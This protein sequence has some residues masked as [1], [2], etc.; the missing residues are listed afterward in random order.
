MVDR[1]FSDAAL[2]D[3]YDAFC[4]WEERGD[5]DY[6]LP[7]IMAADAVLD[8]GCG[9]GM[10][11][12]RAREIGHT[13]RLTGL[14]PAAAMLDVARRRDDIEWVRGTLDSITWDQ[15]FD[16]VVMTGHAF[17]VL[18]TDADVCAALAAVYRALRDG[19]R[20]AFET[21]HPLA[22]QWHA[23]TPDRGVEVNDA[24]GQVVRMEQNVAGDSTDSVVRFSLTYTCPAW[25]EPKVSWSTLR[26][27][28]VDEVRGHLAA[29]GFSIELQEGDWT[30]GPVLDS[31][32]EII[33]IAR[34]AAP[35]F[36]S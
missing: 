17:Q 34:R 9:T 15:E 8:V 10:L 22:R 33:T 32:P 24:A 18:V 12:H 27:L 31:S 4:P 20:F 14:E 28:G 35:T 5:F 29:A 26:F 36:G 19:G 21:R 13:G 16:L 7:H 30:G 3:L 1:V 11:L 2:A 6:Y 25:A 23:W